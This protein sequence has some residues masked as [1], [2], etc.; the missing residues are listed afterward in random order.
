MKPK[1]CKCCNSIPEIWK[2][3]SK[4]NPDYL[5]SC[6]NCGRTGPLSASEVSAIRGWND[7]FKVHSGSSEFAKTANKFRKAELKKIKELR[8][9]FGV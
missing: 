6:T 3:L 2:T 7:N 1:K 4:I 8:K 5:G 9:L